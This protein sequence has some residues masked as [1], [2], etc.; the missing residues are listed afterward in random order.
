M[1]FAALALTALLALSAGCASDDE[2]ADPTTD[3]PAP[4]ANAT[5]PAPLH[6]EGDVPYGADPFNVIPVVTP[7]GG[8]AP[9]STSASTCFVHAFTINGTNASVSLEATLAWDLPASD[10]DLYLYEGE[11]QLSQDG[12]NG[13]PPAAGVP[14]AMQVLRHDGLAAGEYAFWV[15]AWNAVGDAYTLDVTFS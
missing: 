12:I 11:T 15:V 13:I 14:E 3:M 7:V 9:C 8:G 5:A 1:R 6:F 2:T 4:M 10:F